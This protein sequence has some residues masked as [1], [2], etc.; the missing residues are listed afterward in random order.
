MEEIVLNGFMDLKVQKKSKYKVNS[1][2]KNQVFHLN[3][4]RRQVDMA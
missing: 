2:S 3:W 1:F 4:G